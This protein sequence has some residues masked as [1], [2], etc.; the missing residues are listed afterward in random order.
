MISWEDLTAEQVDLLDSFLVERDL[1]LEHKT[2]GA[3]ILDALKSELGL[4]LADLRD[5]ADRRSSWMDADPYAR[6]IADK[7]VDE[8]AWLN[9]R[10]EGVTATEISKLAQGQKAQRANILAEKVSGERSFTG[11]KYTDY[12]LEREPFISEQLRLQHGFTPSDVLFHAVENPRHLATPDGVH[13]DENGI[14][15]ISE[16]KT[17]KNNLDPEGSDFAK[18]TYMDQMQWQ[19]YVMGPN[20][21][22]CLFAWEQH[23]NVWVL[24]PDGVERPTS[25][26]VEKAWVLR[27]QERIDY[28]VSVADEFLA[29]LDWS[30]A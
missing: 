18:T 17:G 25:Y 3:R 7:S 20:C 26:A 5:L 11:N 23:D 22:K 28:L 15:T 1:E 13:V 6:A 9:A 29:D 4:K 27:D 30:L 21:V 10:R 12:G 2:A 16:I 14:I 24:H 8:I 19:M